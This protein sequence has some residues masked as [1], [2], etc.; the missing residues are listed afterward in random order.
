VNASREIR[1][2]ELQVAR[3]KPW[4]KMWTEWIHD[5]KMLSL[6]LA[7]Q[8][9]WWRLVSLAQE[10]AQDGRIAT[11]NGR[12]LN[13]GE[14][15]DCLHL[16]EQEGKILKRMIQKM[17]DAGSLHWDGAV[18]V[19]TKFI[20]RQAKRASDDAAAAA[21]RQRAH[22]ARLSREIRDSQKGLS[23]DP[24]LK[25]T[26]GEGETE[27][28]VEVTDVTLRDRFTKSSLRSRE[29][30]DMNGREPPRQGPS[31]VR[32]SPDSAQEMSREIRDEPDVL[33][34]LATLYEENIGVLTPKIADQF[35]EFTARFRG[36][37]EWIDDAFTEACRQN[38][39]KWA[40]IE[41]I[42][43]T[44]QTEGRGGKTY[45]KSPRE[46]GE[47]G[48]PRPYTREEAEAAGWTV[49]PGDETED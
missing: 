31:K 2:K 29:I 48:A 4:L 17:T 3:P 46:K 1:D 22:R 9:A 27:A 30:R 43:E 28:E 40:Y 36:P 42:L 20:G 16:K 26:E 39:R 15:A 33:G 6:T 32:A 19:I 47:P 21:E 14:I 35:R 25:N 34:R 49:N 10:Q 12:P 18:L 7:E 5:P 24:S 37:V 44:W 23:P 41:K 45:G 13:L 38:V 11:S 8:A